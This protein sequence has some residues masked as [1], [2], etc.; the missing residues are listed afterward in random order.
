MAV[1]YK[2]QRMPWYIPGMKAGE[3]INLDPETFSPVM[4]PKGR[5]E[6]GDQVMVPVPDIPNR[7]SVRKDGYIELILER[8]YDREAKQSRNRKVIIGSD[9][10]GFLPGMMIPNDNYAD[11]FDGNGRLWN[12]EQETEQ[13]EATED[14][15]ETAHIRQEEH[16]EAQTKETKAE[17]K[18][19]KNTQTPKQKEKAEVP[20]N[21]DAQNAAL[22]E[23]ENQ[24]RQK[25]R[26]LQIREQELD[27]LQEQIMVQFSQAE[28]DHISLLSRILDSYID[29]VQHQARRKPDAPMSTKQIRTINELL[30]ELR[31]FFAGSESEDYLHLAEE[32]DEATNTPATT[33]GEMALLLT[34]YQCTVN[35]YFYHDLRKKQKT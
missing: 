33:N 5:I 3:S 19:Q 18:P 6:N 28:K 25:E 22:R 31:T 10:S 14:R 15:Q 35:A 24:L 21:T 7:I 8:H 1:F 16:R 32:P 20:V 4:L 12:K 9:V 17:P 30:E 34:A 13:E 23:W 26:E 2:G 11:L 29:T 27:E